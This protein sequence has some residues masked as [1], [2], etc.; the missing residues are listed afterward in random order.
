VAK[1]KSSGAGTASIAVLGLLLLGGGGYFFHKTL[2][3]GNSEGKLPTRTA[4]GRSDGKGKA[5]KLQNVEEDGGE[6]GSGEEGDS[7]EEDEGEEEEDG[8]EDEEDDGDEDEDE[9]GSEDDE[10]DED[11]SDDL[12]QVRSKANQVRARKK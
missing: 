6:D 1:L 10:E 9:D 12:E 8:E 7:S 3:N 4:N 2:S 11:D 5:Q